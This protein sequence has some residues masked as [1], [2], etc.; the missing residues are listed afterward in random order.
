M[1][2]V[3]TARAPLR[4]SYKVAI[5]SLAFSRSPGLDISHFAFLTLSPGAN[6]D[7]RYW[8]RS[9]KHPLTRSISHFDPEPDV[10]RFDGSVLRSMS[11]PLWHETNMT[12]PVGDVRSRGTT[13]VAFRGHEVAF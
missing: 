1:K 13:E 12:G 3:L 6:T 4:T 7:V 10:P 8:R 9:G 5:V 11:P 2:F